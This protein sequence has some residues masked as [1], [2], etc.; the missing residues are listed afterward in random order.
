MLIRG[1]LVKARLVALNGDKQ[2][3]KGEQAVKNLQV[4]LGYVKQALDIISTP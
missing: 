2:L 1:L 4:A 3:L